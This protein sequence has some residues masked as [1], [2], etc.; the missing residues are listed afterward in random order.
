M[1]WTRIGPSSWAFLALVISFSA[2]G[3]RALAL[4]SVVA[5]PSAANSDAARLAII[6]CWCCELPPKLRARRGVAGMV[7]VSV[8]FDQPRS[9]RPRSSS[10]CL[11]SSRLFWPKLV[12]LSRSSSVLVSSSP[13]VLIWARLRQLRGRSDR[14][15]SSIGRSRSGERGGDVGDLAE[16]EALRLVAQVGD[17]VDQRAQR[18]AGR[19]ERLA[20]RD[21][22]V[23]LDVEDE[24]VVVGALLDA[25]RLDLEHHAADRREDR[26]D[27]DDADGAVLRCHGRSTGSHGRGSTVR[28]TARR[29]LALSVAM[30]RS[31]L[32]ISIS[33][34]ALDVAGGDRRPGHARRGAARCP[35]RL[36]E[37]STMSLRFKM[38][39]VT[40][41]AMPAIVSN[42]CSASSK[43]TAVMAAPGIDDSRVRRS[44]LPMRVAEA[45]LER[46]DGEPLAVVVFVADGFDGGALNDEHEGAFDCLVGFELLG[47]EL[48]DERLAH[49]HVDVLALREGRGR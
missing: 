36:I 17:E 33:A 11:T 46:A 6:S 14:S 38:M 19:G 31:L 34:R 10:F 15:R 22:T 9:V 24:A 39:S 23:G 18:G 7:G 5:M 2:I 21:R 26:V 27:R 16:L 4:A 12:M 49:G 32:R 48:D 42:S 29:P 25:G 45:G 35:R 43:R 44:E 37:V 41:S 30:C 28:S 40:S 8:V 47:V 13:T 3:R 20:R 1:R